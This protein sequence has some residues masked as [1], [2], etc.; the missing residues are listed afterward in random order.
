MNQISANIKPMIKPL[1][2]QPIGIFDSG[3]G[4][5]TVAHAL[6]SHLPNE[7]IIYFGDTAHLPYGDK[8]ATTIQAYSIKIANMLLQQQC[9]LILIAC[10]S[11]S[12]AAYELV[13]E[14]ISNQAIVM[15]VID[16][17]IHLL[18]DQYANKQIGLIG[19]RQTVNS[20]V[21]KK[22]IDALNCGIQLTSLATNLLASAIEEFGNSKAIDSIL[23]EYLSNK[24]L[25][26]L[27]ALVLAC[28]HYPIVK[29]KI[30]KYFQ[31]KM[32][33]IDPSDTVA[34]AV[35]A[36][37][38]ADDLLKTNGVGEKQFYVSDY[39]ESFANGTKIFFHETIP[40]QHYPLW[41]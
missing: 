1:T 10:S 6:V 18:R 9:K 3:I 24:T 28:T 30:A 40:L 12:A 15:N 11:A 8:S 2:S 32:E 4:G 14:Y 22:K 20:N 34:K 16:P 5:L 36:R 25:Q 13:K 19:T 27:D 37:L 23:E 7:N 39:T 38:A 29:Q 17:I 21:Y 41:D 26:N 31:N 33:I 35:K